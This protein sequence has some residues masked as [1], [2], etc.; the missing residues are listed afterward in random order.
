MGE[1]IV[2]GRKRS[3]AN[4][5]E[6]VVRKTPCCRRYTMKDKL[7]YVSLTDKI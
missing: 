1:K 5:G 4:R 7:L 2:E 6:E 3:G